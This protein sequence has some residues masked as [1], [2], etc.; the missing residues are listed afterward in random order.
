LVNRH[1][2]EMA[3]PMHALV[4][5]M[6]VVTLVLLLAIVPFLLLGDAFEAA[7]RSWLSERARGREFAMGVVA[8][9]AADMILPVPSSGVSTLA[10]ARLGIFWATAASWLGMSIGSVGGFALAR[11]LGEPLVRRTIGTE[12]MHRLTSITHACGSLAIA[13]TRPVPVL[14]EAAVLLLGATRLA[15]KK[16]LPVVLLSNFAIALV[17][18]ILGWLSFARGQ[19][20]IALAASIA[21]PVLATLIARRLLPGAIPLSSPDPLP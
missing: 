15:W 13:L 9:L 3:T 5:P 17:Y 10:G 19:L 18:S 4:R 2:E 11:W 6:L 14:A 12:D 20:A 7:L 21:L 16:F 8:L 1:A